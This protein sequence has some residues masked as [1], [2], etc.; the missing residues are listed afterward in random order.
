MDELENS[1]YKYTANA[2]FAQAT[3]DRKSA[4]SRRHA[5]GPSGRLSGHGS[6]SGFCHERAK[7]QA[8]PS[9]GGGV[10]PPK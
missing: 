9:P 8:N 1:S 2:C 6:R 5:K 10:P 3:E 4:A 7:Y